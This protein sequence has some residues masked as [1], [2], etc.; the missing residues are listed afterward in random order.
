MDVDYLVKKSETA[1]E[2]V[3]HVSRILPYDFFLNKIDNV[4][5]RK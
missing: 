4:M 5:I 1:K 2:E 3:I